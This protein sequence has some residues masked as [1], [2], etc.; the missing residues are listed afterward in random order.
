[1]DINDLAKKI[2][3]YLA[4]RPLVVLGSGASVPYGLPTMN[5]LAFELKKDPQIQAEKESG[6]LFS[7]MITIGLEAAIDK[8]MLT[9]NAKKRIREVTWKC[10]SKEDIK[11][12]R[13]KELEDRLQPIVLMIK[14]V[15]TASPNQMTI[16]TTNYDRLSEYAADIYGATTVTGFEGSL[17]RRFDGFSAKVD[18]KRIAAR[19]RVV[20]ILKVH[21]SIDWFE[22]E[23]ENIVSRPDQANIPSGYAPLIVPPGKDKYSATHKEPYRTVIEEADKEFGKAGSF[24]CVGY[25]FND[26]HIQPKLISQ[27]KNVGKPIVV[28]TKKATDE[29]LRLVTDTNVQKYLILE[30]DKTQT[31][32]KSN[33]GEYTV[34]GC[35]WSLD[36]FMK[37]W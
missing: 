11:L 14:K 9:E 1:M 5:S 29:C 31:K 19:E 25:G 36:E 7:D 21:G 34:K 20:K 2:Q 32:V 18:G 24:L 17:L 8:N 12:L 6:R 10:I 3:E 13:D 33:D 22:D 23:N 27:I 26:S 30:E 15:I 37:V 4:D 16:V 35:V 28:I